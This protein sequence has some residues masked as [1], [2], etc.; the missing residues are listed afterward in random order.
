MKTFTALLFSLFCGNT[1]FA[2][3][4]I[5]NKTAPEAVITFDT[6]GDV[7]KP[8]A[9]YIG[10]ANNEHA[11]FLTEKGWQ[12]YVSGLFAPFATY[13]TTG[14]PGVIT[15]RVPFP[16]GTVS[17]RQY[18]GYKIGVGWG[19]LTAEALA[20]IEERRKVIAE[21]R[22]DGTL[23]Q[24]RKRATAPSRKPDS[25]YLKRLAAELTQA[26]SPERTNA[27]I[28]EI[29]SVSLIGGMSQEQFHNIFEADDQLKL[30]FVQKDMIGDANNVLQISGKWTNT[31][32]GT[33]KYRL[34]TIPLVECLPSSGSILGKN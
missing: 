25:A 21:A 3:E 27:L 32:K 24:L 6:K 19:A 11:W 13:E 1:G 22:K 26:K 18:Q 29:E 4:V 30:A 7:G 34:E 8:G 23:D 9:I 28:Q 20:Q 14:L 15:V 31:G 16:P 17:T 10:L 5:C 2:L 12:Q 33:G